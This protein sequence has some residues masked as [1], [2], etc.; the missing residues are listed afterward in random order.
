MPPDEYEFL[1][2]LVAHLRLLDGVLASIRPT[3]GA[4]SVDQRD[5]LEAIHERLSKRRRSCEIGFAKT[6]PA[7]PWTAVLQYRASSLENW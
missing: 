3:I 7:G 5:E 1:K 4:A 6:V 2:G